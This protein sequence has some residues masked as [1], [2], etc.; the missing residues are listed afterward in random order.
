MKS[1]TLP[2]LKALLLLLCTLCGTELIAQTIPQKLASA[3]EAFA[4]DP[5]L[6]NGI[7]SLYVVDAKT[8]EVVFGKNELLGLVPASTQKVITSASAYELLGRDFRYK[9]RFAYRREGA[10]A[11]LLVLPGGDP[12]LGSWRWP[13]TKEAAVLAGLARA[14]AKLGIKAFGTVR[15]DNSGWQTEAIPDGWIWQDIGNYYGAGAAK[16]N[17]RENQFDV[18]LKSGSSIGDPVAITAVVPPVSGYRLTS[19]LTSAAAGSGDKAYIYFPIQS[20]TGTI[21]GTIPVNQSRYTI[22]GAMP[23]PSGQF[24]SAWQEALAGSGV[25]L[26]R[27][28]TEEGDLAAEAGKYTVFHTITSPPLDSIVYFFN[29]ESINLYGEAL[30]KTMAHAQAGAGATAK[31]AELV[32]EF[33]KQRGIPDTELCLMDGSGLSPL[34]R[35]TAHAQVSV[36]QHARKQPWFEGFYTS[37]PV[38]NGMRM[39]SGTLQG[40]KGYCGYHRGKDGREYAFSFLVNNYNGPSGTLVRKMYGVLD[41]LK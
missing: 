9:T 37:L 41:V 40:V 39:K 20:A 22:S 28:I 27:K 32:R 16:L 4:K 35:V 11:A 8:G 3:F 25:Q 1:Q 29:R 15:L 10:S 26:P 14:T 19:A 36:L 31:G 13:S 7:A 18:T 21:R 34:N 6:R 30:L 23:D 17:W 12:T 2:T 33:W 5:Q 38:Y 24:V